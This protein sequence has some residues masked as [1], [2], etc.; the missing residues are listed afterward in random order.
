MKR[1]NGVIVHKEKIDH[2][3]QSLVDTYARL[4]QVLSV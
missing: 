3:S 1:D 2:V 4:S